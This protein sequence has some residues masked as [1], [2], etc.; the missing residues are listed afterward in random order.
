MSSM[1]SSALNGRKTYGSKTT[2]KTRK[3]DSKIGAIDNTITAKR[4]R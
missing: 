1:H 4:V 3:S 2:L